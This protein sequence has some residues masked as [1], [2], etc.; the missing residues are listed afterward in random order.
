LRY[1]LLKVKRLTLNR[2]EQRLLLFLEQNR[3]KHVPAPLSEQLESYALIT[4]EGNLFQIRD[5]QSGLIFPLYPI[6]AAWLS[7]PATECAQ[8]GFQDVTVERQPMTVM[9]HTALMDGRQVRLYVGGSLEDDM[10]ILSTYQSTLLLLL[11]CLLGL[12]AAGGHFLSRRAMRPV[13]RMTKAAL[14]IG[15]GKLSSRLP[16]PSAQDEL[17]SLWNQLLDHL[18]RV[19]SRV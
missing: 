13:D 9:C 11:P 8:P 7:H 12:A 19:R 10:Y 18:E 4:H 5:L 6:G 14:D 16:L 3:Q 2:R 15:I 17:W 1:V